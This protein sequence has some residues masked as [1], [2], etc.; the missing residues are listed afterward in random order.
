MPADDC[1]IF[2]HSADDGSVSLPSWSGSCLLIE[3]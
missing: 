1:P 2:M 3:F